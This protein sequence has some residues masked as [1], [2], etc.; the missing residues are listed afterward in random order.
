MY[1]A[2]NGE[3][4]VFAAWAQ[5]KT[6]WRNLLRA[7]PVEVILRGRRLVATGEAVVDDDAAS[8]AAWNGY[9][10]KFPKADLARQRGD[11]PLFVRITLAQ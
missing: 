2:R 4:I 6:W 1:A 9:L 11:N 7:T 5:E 8:R 3:L 10:L